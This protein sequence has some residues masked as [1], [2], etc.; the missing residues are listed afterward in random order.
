MRGTPPAAAPQ[1]KTVQRA[2]R[3]QPSQET[4]DVSFDHLVGAG[5]DGKRNRQAEGFCGLQIDYQLEFRRPL[6][7]KIGR[8][9]ALQ[10]G[11]ST[12]W[13]LRALALTGGGE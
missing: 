10:E 8:F 4:S 1:R 12:C 13:N 2:L 3:R 7:G 9:G 6:D 5:E 11:P